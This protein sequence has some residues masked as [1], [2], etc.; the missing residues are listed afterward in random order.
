VTVT[1]FD[2]SPGNQP[3]ALVDHFL[4]DRW[5]EALIVTSRGAL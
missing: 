1:V 5:H 3:Q 2:Q 4:R